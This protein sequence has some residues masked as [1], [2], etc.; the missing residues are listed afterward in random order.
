MKRAS[1]KL[2]LLGVLMLL[3]IMI[4]LNIV[5][6]FTSLNHQTDD[7]L[8][9]NIAGRQRMLTQKMSKSALLLNDPSVSN[10]FKETVRTELST[11]ISLFNSTL[12]GF[13]EGGEIVDA[14]GNKTI[15]NN[16]GLSIPL[17]EN[18]D[19]LWKPFKL[20][21]ESI[22]EGENA[23][24]LE[25][26]YQNNNQLLSLSNDVAVD[27]QQTSD[28]RV[29]FLKTFQYFVMALSLIILI[30]SYIIINRIIIKPV[31]TLLGGFEDVSNGDL[32]TRVNY[33]NSDEIGKLIEGFN[34]MVNNLKDLVSNSKGLAL[35]VQASTD[36]LHEMI[37]QTSEAI[38][39]VSEATEYIA[40]GTSEQAIASSESVSMTTKLEH[41]AEV[42]LDLTTSL[43][44]QDKHMEDLSIK[45]KQVIKYLQ[46]QQITSIESVSNVDQVITALGNQVDLISHFTTTIADIASQTNLLALNAAIEAARAGD[47]GKGFAVVADEIRKLAVQSSAS[48]NEI[49]LVVHDIV[50]NMQN[51]I[52]RVTETIQIANEQGDTVN[53]VHRLFNKLDQ[54]IGKSNQYIECV[55]REISQL[56]AFNH[57][58]VTSIQQISTVAETTAA[59]SQQ[60]SASIQQQTATMSIIN[61]H[62]DDLGEKALSLKNSL[63]TFII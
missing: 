61:A 25:F 47:M 29:A 17:A 5:V 42:I 28:E 50:S 8:L 13:I 3:V 27:L 14:E 11:S 19:T 46:D 2:K 12:H 16:I 57:D 62:V 10:E 6:I 38:S 9:I 31:K 20:N 54:S 18:V 22:L 37:R 49:Q 40:N 23:T 39:Q 15:I 35:E 55:Y 1:I 36:S 60:V 56:V 24:A 32:N 41:N 26:I 59:S 44:D 45:G 63:T 21:L 51:A 7:G 53:N 30:A 48:A 58:I 43:K 34:K 33:N 52:S 4:A